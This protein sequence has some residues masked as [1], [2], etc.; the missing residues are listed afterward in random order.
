MFFIN[1]LDYAFIRI[2][3]PAKA[4]RSEIPLIGKQHD[5]YTFAGYLLNNQPVFLNI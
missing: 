5:G 3:L 1:S 2:R 4:A